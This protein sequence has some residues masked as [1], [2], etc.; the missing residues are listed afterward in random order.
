MCTGTGIASLSCILHVH[1]HVHCASDQL[2]KRVAFDQMRNVW[3]NARAFG[4]LRCTLANCGA[5]LPKC[6]VHLPKCAAHLVKLTNNGQRRTHL[7]KCASIW[8]IVLRIW[9]KYSELDLMCNA[10][11][12]LSTY[13]TKM[14][15]Q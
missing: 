2:T 11:C 3:S 10:L 15:N 5:H 12:S 13:S 6:S 8:P 9:P 7:V 1:V 14:C 4:Q